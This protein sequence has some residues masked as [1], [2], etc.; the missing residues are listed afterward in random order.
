MPIKEIEDEIRKS[1]RVRLIVHRLALGVL[2]LIS[3]FVPERYAILCFLGV[4]VAVLF[5]ISIK[6]LDIY[7]LKMAHSDTITNLLL[8]IVQQLNK[9]GLEMTR[10]PKKKRIEKD[11]NGGQLN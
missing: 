9:R 8:T 11:E 10:S 2:V 6:V 3:I 4:L 5:D 7:H 1:E